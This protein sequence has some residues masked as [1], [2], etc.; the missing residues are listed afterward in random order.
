MAVRLIKEDATQDKKLDLIKSTVEEMKKRVSEVETELKART[1]YDIKL[2]LKDLEQYRSSDYHVDFEDV[3]VLDKCG[4]FKA[5]LKECV[6]GNFN[7][8]MHVQLTTQDKSYSLY[9]SIAEAPD[10]VKNKVKEYLKDS[11]DVSFN[12]VIEKGLSFEEL[13]AELFNYSENRYNRLLFS[14]EFSKMRLYYPYDKDV[15]IIWGDLNLK[16]SHKDGGSN[17][18]EVL[19]YQFSSETNKF[20]FR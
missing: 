14:P 20:L 16:Y 8:G 18:M 10:L 17:G 9:D 5:A 4:I 12:D 19:R 15:V 13:A 7:S 1:G 6:L 2:T 3:D 11:K